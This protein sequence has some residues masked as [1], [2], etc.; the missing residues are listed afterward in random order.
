MKGTRGL[1]GEFLHALESGLLLPILERVLNDGTLDL[2]IR[3]DYIN[4]YY[5]GGNLSK[6]SLNPRGGFSVGFDD[7]YFKGTGAKKPNL[8]RGLQVSKDVDAWLSALPELKQGMDFWIAANPRDE[9]EVQQRIVRVNNWGK[10]A[11]GTDYFI[12]DFEYQSPKGRF[13]L[14]GVRWPSKGHLRK[15]GRSL[16]LALI[17]VKYADDALTGKAGLADHL[18]DIKSYV[19]ASG[20]LEGIAEEM[21]TVF[22]QKRRLGLVD[23]QKDIE[24]F[25]LDRVEL[26]F[27]LANHDPESRK[28]V[29][30]LARLHSTPQVEVTFATAN[31][32]GYGLYLDG[33]FPLADF[34]TRLR[35]HIYS[36]Q[37][38]ED[39]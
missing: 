38:E 8:P 27:A 37:N 32:M 36:K 15:K 7:N 19:A 12:C 25:D 34:Q 17:E 4:L 2:E 26:M 21:K 31:F 22:N 29:R 39:S 11:T 28:L 3:D 18:R 20:N 35:D 23:N 13:D 33:I 9:K 24:S 16:T 30:E 14:I 10:V 1:S 5:R 6:I